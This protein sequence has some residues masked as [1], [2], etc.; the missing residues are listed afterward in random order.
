MGVALDI[1]GNEVDSE[2]G[3]DGKVM[4]STLLPVLTNNHLQNQEKIGHRCF[5]A[6]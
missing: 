2:K 6:V 4:M 5:D 1:V 3:K